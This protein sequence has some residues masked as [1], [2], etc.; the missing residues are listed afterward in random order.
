[1]HRLLLAVVSALTIVLTS[2]TLPASAYEKK[3]GHLWRHDGVLRAGCHHYRYHYAL[4]PHADDWSLETFLVGPNHKGLGN[5]AF[6]KGD[7][8]R[9]GHRQFKI[10]RNTTQPGRFKIRGK[11]TRTQVS[12]STPLTCTSTDD[13]VWIKPARFRLR[14]R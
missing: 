14:H 6:Q 9:R 10:C 1:M 13:V 3:Y 4:H 11:L 8:P 7:A 12:C 5:D 2:T